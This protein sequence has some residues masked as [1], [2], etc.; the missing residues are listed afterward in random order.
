[1]IFNWN[2]AKARRKAAFALY[3]AAVVQSRLPLYYSDWHVPDTLDGRFEVLCLHMALLLRRLNRED[4]EARELATET[5]D[6]MFADMDQELREMGVGDLGVGK[7]VR[8]MGAALYGRMAAYDAAL[9]E[10][11]PREMD[12][13][14]RRNLYGTAQ[15]AVDTAPAAAYLRR[16]AEALDG[17]APGDLKAGLVRFPPPGG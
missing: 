10:A 16:M 11:D 12:G 3:G 7:R 9:A 15:G 6:M 8:S 4:L 2:K 13:A 1:M 5:M 17:Q 14:L